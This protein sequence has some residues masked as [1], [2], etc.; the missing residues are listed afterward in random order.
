MAQNVRTSDKTNPTSRCGSYSHNE[1]SLVAAWKSGELSY[2]QDAPGEMGKSGSAGASGSNECRIRHG[3]R[4][5]AVP[6]G[7]LT[8][9][10]VGVDDHMC[11]ICDEQIDRSS[12]ARGNKR[13]IGDY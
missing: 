2:F 13:C 4:V 11:R 3:S 9:I 5:I 7:L 10:S 6:A 8:E 1:A 12:C